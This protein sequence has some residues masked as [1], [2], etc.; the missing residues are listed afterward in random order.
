[1]GLTEDMSVT[2]VADIIGNY[3]RGSA[4]YNLQTPKMPQEQEDFALWF[5]NDSDRGYC[6]HFA[7]AATVLLRAAGIPVTE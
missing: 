4:K 1:M 7:S 3:V 5:L 6:I 2:Q